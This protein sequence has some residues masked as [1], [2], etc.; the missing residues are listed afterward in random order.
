MDIAQSPHLTIFEGWNLEARWEFSSVRGDYNLG[1]L[2]MMEPGDLSELPTS[3]PIYSSTGSCSHH[4]MGN[5]GT[6][7]IWNLGSFYSL[8]RAHS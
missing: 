1:N 3:L 7:D 5:F 4:S 6:L 2:G 8:L